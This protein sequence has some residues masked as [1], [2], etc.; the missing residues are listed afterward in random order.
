MSLRRAYVRIYI[1]SVLTARTLDQYFPV[2]PSHS[3]SKRLLL[4]GKLVHD[5]KENSDWFPERSEFA[6]RT[7][8]MDRSEI[9]SVSCFS[10]TLHKSASRKYIFLYVWGIISVKLSR[11]R[12]EK[13]NYMLNFGLRLARIDALIYQQNITRAIII[14]TLLNQPLFGPYCA[15]YGPCLRLGP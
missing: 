5:E 8:Q 12:P 4:Y 9:V 2:Q 6:I 7:A 13:C 3:T 10:K 1:D 15:N 14:N 11:K